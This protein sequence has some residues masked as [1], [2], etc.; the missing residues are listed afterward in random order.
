MHPA[1]NSTQHDSILTTNVPEKIRLLKNKT[2]TEHIDSLFNLDHYK[3]EDFFYN[4]MHNLPFYAT[5]SYL[6][7]YYLFATCSVMIDSFSHSYYKRKGKNFERQESIKDSIQNVDKIKSSKLRSYEAPEVNLIDPGSVNTITNHNYKY[8]QKIIKQSDLLNKLLNKK[9]PAKARKS[10]WINLFE[11][12]IYKVK[13]NLKFSRNFVNTYAVAFMIIYFFTLFFFRFTSIFNDFLSKLLELSQQ[14]IYGISEYLKYEEHNFHFE[15]K[16]ACVFTSLLLS[17]Q[18]L[19]SIRTF[20][21]SVIQHHRGQLRELINKYN[22][23][24]YQKILKKRN[25]QAEQTTSDSIHFSGYLVAHLVYGYIV[26]LIVSFV[27]ILLGKF[28]FYFPQIF[29]SILQIFFPIFIL[30]TF[31]HL[32]LKLMTKCLFLTNKNYRIKNSSA[33]HVSSFFNFFF[34]CFLGL[35]SCLSRVWLSN[36]ISLFYLTRLDKTSFNKDNDLTMQI[37]DKGHLAYINY[38]RMEHWY[39]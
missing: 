7:S 15:L 3:N 22:F 6:L 9:Q 36:L 2:L 10:F 20:Q 31:K 4:V 13:S 28:L 18:M 5:I 33:Y 23:Y 14:Y 16:L 32:V 34:D 26:L 27:V 25:E 12:R 21:Q 35:L 38:V 19:L 17:I 24:H 29:W 8:I 37:L 11:K 30:L 39:K 1:V